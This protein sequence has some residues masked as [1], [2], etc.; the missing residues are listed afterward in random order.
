M[1]TPILGLCTT[2][3]KTADLE[4]AKAWYAKAF[5]TE[6]YY[7]QAPYVGFNVAGYDLGLFLDDTATPDGADNVLTY[8]GVEDMDAAMAHFQSLD[9]TVHEAPMNVGGDIVTASLRDPWGNVIGLIY[10]PEL[11]LP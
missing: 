7:D 1:S 5:Q 2:I 8:W 3:Y 10:N 6:P 4:A 9:A 11:V